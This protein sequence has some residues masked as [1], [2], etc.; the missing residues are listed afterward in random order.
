VLQARMQSE[1][2]SVPRAVGKYQGA[3]QTIPKQGTKA[4]VRPKQRQPE[5]TYSVL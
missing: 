1:V 4:L 5:G 2:Q 3:N